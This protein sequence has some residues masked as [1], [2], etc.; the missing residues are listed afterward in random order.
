MSRAK[1]KQQAATHPHRD[2]RK[3]GLVFRAPEALVSFAA[4]RR[5][6]GAK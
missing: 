3:A 5:T 1:V 6:P 2:W 4:D